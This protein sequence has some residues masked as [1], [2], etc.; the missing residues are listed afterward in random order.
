MKRK[1]ALT[2]FGRGKNEKK[3]FDTTVH[4]KKKL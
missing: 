4:H 3:N 1:E 2:G